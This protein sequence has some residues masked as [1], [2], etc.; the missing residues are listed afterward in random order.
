MHAG[1]ANESSELE[2]DFMSD[3]ETAVADS[4]RISYYA[5]AK[6]WADGR[7]DALERSR[8]LAWLISIIAI[9]VA[10]LEAVALA[11]LAPLKRVE[12]Y[13]LLVDR[14]TGFVQILKGDGTE[15]IK[16]DE[17]LVQSMLAQYVIARESF[18][19]NTLARDYRKVGLWSAARARTNYLSAMR[20][21]SVLNPINNL[22]RTTVVET[23]IKS[24]S[25]L[26]PST[27][28][29]RFDTVQIDQGL[30]GGNPKPWIA[31]L[32]FRFAK[33]PMSFED[34]LI[35]PLGFQVVSYR[36]DQEAPPSAPVTPF[37]PDGPAETG[38]FAPGTEGLK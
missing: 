6:S 29:V 36:R 17:S 30:Q 5:Q 35:N 31:V 34:R 22:P 3:Y 33:A 38:D 20:S 21:D 4:D 12:P 28:L 19:I 10:V 14:Q 9:S 27:A 16:A 23:R 32:R 8:R 37:A 26:G 1:K 15:R 2:A 25:R 7:R 13:A 11:A 18:D 24:V